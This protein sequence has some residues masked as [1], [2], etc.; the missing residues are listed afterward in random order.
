MGVFTEGSKVP[1]IGIASQVP[2]IGPNLTG[3]S[4]HGLRPSTSLG[5]G[6]R[7]VASLSLMAVVGLTSRLEITVAL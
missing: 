3:L 2:Q 4:L 7:P 1:S 6:P 5:Q